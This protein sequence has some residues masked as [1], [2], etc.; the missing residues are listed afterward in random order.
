MGMVASGSE[1]AGLPGRMPRDGGQGEVHRHVVVVAGVDDEH[2]RRDRRSQRVEAARPGQHLG[3]PRK[4]GRRAP[5]RPGHRRAVAER[6]Q[7]RD[8]VPRVVKG[9]R[10]PGGPFRATGNG[11]PVRTTPRMSAAARATRSATI[12]PSEWSMATVPGAIA[13]R[14]AASAASASRGSVGVVT[15]PWVSSRPRAASQSEGPRP[16]PW[17]QTSRRSAMKSYF[18]E[19]TLGAGTEAA[20]AEEVHAPGDT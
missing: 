17:R 15:G 7:E 9:G 6:T 8:P 18:R 12:P 2:R 13:A 16:S 5:A 14:A 1:Q 10:T 4:S 11:Q 3:D 19:D 20:G